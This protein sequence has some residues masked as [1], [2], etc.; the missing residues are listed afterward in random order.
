MCAHQYDQQTNQVVCK[1][2]PERIY[3]DN[4]PD[5]N[6]FGLEPNFGCCTANL[7]QGW[8]KF[9]ETPL[10]AHRRRRARRHRLCA[11]AVETRLDGKRVVVSLATDYPFGD[12]LRFTSKRLSECRSRSGCGF[13]RGAH[14]PN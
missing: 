8:P 3:V 12:T 9:A 14:R 2:R 11:L 1:V 5:A 4:G 10:D 6:L 7:H 13:R